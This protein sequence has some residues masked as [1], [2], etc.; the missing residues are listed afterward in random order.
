MKRLSDE[1]LQSIGAEVRRRREAAGL[2]MEGLAERAELH[3]NYISRIELGQA[4]FSV[5]A[6][7]AIAGA[8]DGEVGDLFPGRQTSVEPG[9]LAAAR[10][11]SQADPQVRA[12]VRTLLERVPTKRRSRRP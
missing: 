10:L 5:S 7:W 8:L 2:S 9:V 12:A 3:K 1:I 6:L 4:D 11:F